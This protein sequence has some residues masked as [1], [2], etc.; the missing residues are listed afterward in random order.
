MC[1]QLLDKVDADLKK[2]RNYP[3]V[4]MLIVL[5]NGSIWIKPARTQK[6]W[7]LASWMAAW[8]IVVA[9]VM[10]DSNE[11]QKREITMATVEQR[12]ERLEKSQ[13][14][15]RVATMALLCLMVAGVSMGQTNGVKDIVCRSLKI[16]G[17]NNSPAV[18]IVAWPFGGRI[19]VY[20][21]VGKLSTSISQTFVDDGLVSVMAK[22]GLT[23][24]EIKANENG[25]QIMILNK[26]KARKEVVTMSVNPSGNGLLVIGNQAGESIVTLMSDKDDN[27]AVW[28]WGQGGDSI[29]KLETVSQ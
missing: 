2:E 12:L 3:C 27:G 6:L 20:N 10:R 21:S 7:W 29:R 13:K 18:D 1:W 25:G 19:N 5:N 26:L 16:V 15:Y 23:A 11:I 14:R 28:V 24:T 17:E 4:Y 22:D 8:C 9:Q